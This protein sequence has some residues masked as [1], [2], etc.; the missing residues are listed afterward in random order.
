[1][2]QYLMQGVLHGM[3]CVLQWSDGEI[4]IIMI[5]HCCSA[6]QRVAACCSVLPTA[7][8]PRA[9]CRRCRHTS[10]CHSLCTPTGPYLGDSG[11]PVLGCDVQP[12]PWKRRLEMIVE[13]QIEILNGQEIF[14]I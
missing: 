3:P 10:S 13:M 1:V 5:S 14:V 4:I 7:L 9:V 6:L 2:V 11:M 8:A 12:V